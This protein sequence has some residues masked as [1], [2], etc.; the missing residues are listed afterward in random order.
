MAWTIELRPPAQKYLKKADR[1]TADRITRFLGDRVATLEDPRSIGKALTGPLAAYWS[2][3]VGEHRLIC[4]LIDDRLIVLVLK[5]GD[6][7]DVYR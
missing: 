2:Y 7:K 5:I 6:R 1:Q 3:R 4:E